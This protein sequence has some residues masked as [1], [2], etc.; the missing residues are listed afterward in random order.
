MSWLT[1]TL[2]SNNI[3]LGIITN[4]KKVERLTNQKHIILDYLKN[5]KSHP[6]TEEIFETVKEKLPRISLGTVYRNL[7]IF[8]KKNLIREISG[9]VKR[10]D[11]DLSSHHHFICS[12]CD[13]VFDL[14]ETKLPQKE[15]TQKVKKIGIIKSYSLFVYGICKKCKNK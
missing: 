5:T 2:I 1:R 12:S 9:K 8:L 6:T 3:Y 15:I 7:D 10:Y 4:N 14:D 11:A 13:K